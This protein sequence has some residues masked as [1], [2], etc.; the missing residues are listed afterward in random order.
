MIRYT[1]RTARP[2]NVVTC[3][4]NHILARLPWHWLKVLR[5]IAR[6]KE[7]HLKGLITHSHPTQIEF[8]WG[9]MWWRTTIVS[10]QTEVCLFE[11]WFPFFF[12]D[13]L[14]FFW[15]L[16]NLF[17]CLWSYA[18]QSDPQQREREGERLRC[19]RL[20][21]RHREAS[22]GVPSITW[23]QTWALTCGSFVAESVC[24]G[25]SLHKGSQDC[26]FCGR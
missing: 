2:T 12:C 8:A 24:N 13:Q 4:T 7:P 17:I 19:G 16:R 10:W 26:S 25:M 1:P 9:W 23:Q 18:E 11:I 15:L 22:E 3:H 5:A 14:S 21:D 6:N 20:T